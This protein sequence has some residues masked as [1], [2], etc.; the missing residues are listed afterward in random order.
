MH[1]TSLF[2]YVC[3]I[4]ILNRQNVT[5]KNFDFNFKFKFNLN[6]NGKEFKNSLPL[7]TSVVSLKFP[8]FT[9]DHFTINRNTY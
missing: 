1:L 7:I 6:F 5:F 2:V 9:R 3:Q 8:P 4:A